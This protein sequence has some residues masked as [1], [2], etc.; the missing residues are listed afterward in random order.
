V[1]IHSKIFKLLLSNYSVSGGLLAALAP[2]G[3]GRHRSLPGTTGTGTDTNRPGLFYG[4][5]DTHFVLNGPKRYDILKILIKYAIKQPGTVGA[6]L[7]PIQ[8]GQGRSL[9]VGVGW[10]RLGPVGAGAD[11]RSPR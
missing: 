4:V 3:T 5:I 2:V 8:S 7:V 9:P 10:G 6:G 11:T 1:K